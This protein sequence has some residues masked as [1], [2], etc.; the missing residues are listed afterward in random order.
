MTHDKKPAGIAAKARDIG[1][2]PL[3]NRQ[4]VEKAIVARRI[5]RIFL[6]QIGM[7]EKAERTHAVVAGDIDDALGGQSGAGHDGRRR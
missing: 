3:E 6:V 5:V 2:N 4:L 1:M 7:G